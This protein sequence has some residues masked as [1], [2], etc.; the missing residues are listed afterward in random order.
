[1]QNKKKIYIDGASR[2][3]PGQAGIGSVCY[4]AS[5]YKIFELSYK[6]PNCTNN[7]AEYSALLIALYSLY[8]SI[9]GATHPQS[10]VVYS[11]SLLLVNQCTMKYKINN[12]KIRKAFLL[13]RDNFVGWDV[14]FIHILRQYNKEAD[15]LANKGIDEAIFL[16]DSIFSFIAPLFL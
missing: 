3:N 15:A 14:Q 13:Y 16:P 10:V 4:D 1:M 9:N 12:D 5:D 7:M 8:N 2:G 6:I 11:D